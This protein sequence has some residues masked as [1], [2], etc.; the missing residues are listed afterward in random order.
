MTANVEGSSRARRAT[1]AVLVLGYLAF[2][3]LGPLAPWQPRAFWTVVLPLLVLA[4]VLGGFHRWRSVCPLAFFGELGRKLNRGVQRKV[5]ERLERFYLVVPFCFL[6]V[7]LLLRLVATNGD[8]RWLSA[9]LVGLAAAAFATN[10]RFTGK[11]W[12]NFFCP[13][14]VVERIYTDPSSPSRSGNSQCARCTA[15]KRSCP[16]IDQENSYWRELRDGGRRLATF[17]FPG[18]VLAFYGYFWLR[19]GDWEAYFDGRWTRHAADVALAFGPGFFFAPEVPA[20]VAAA[21]TLMGLSAASYALWSGVEAALTGVVRDEERRRHLVLSLAAFT[22]FSLFYF[23]AGAPTLRKIPGG[24]H[25][26]AFATPIVATVVLARRWRRSRES[27]VREKAAAKLLR[28]WPLP[29]PPPADP[30]EAYALFK[31][32]EQARERVL[33][34]YTQTMREILAEGIVRE[35]EL[36]L[37]EELRKQFGITPREHEGVVSR[38]AEEE[39]E[40]LAG[41][42]SSVENRV[43]LE[44]YQAALTEALLRSAPEREIDELRRAFG[45]TPAAHAALRE[46]MRGGAGP[47]VAR[48]RRHHAEVVAL[49]SDRAAIEATPASEG[50]D[51]VAYLLRKSE[52]STLGR[53]FDVLETV[54]DAERIAPLRA[55]LVGADRDARRRALAQLAEACPGAEALVAELEPLIVERAAAAADER[56]PIGSTLERLTAAGDPYL[57]DGAAWLAATLASARPS[58]ARYAERSAVEKMQF[59]RQ[60]PIFAELEPEDLDDLSALVREES[61]APTGTLCE[62]GVPDAGDLFVLLEGSAAV[63]V[64]WRTDDPAS[65]REVAELGANEVVGELSLLDG[66]P[67]SATVR[68]KGGPLRLL[69]IPGPAF[70][71]RLLHRERVGQSLLLT[72]THRLRRLSGRI[73]AAE[74]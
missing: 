7:M 39:R 22:A 12:C 69:R 10:W 41:G 21:M 20:L 66:S 14:G 19:A 56:E 61:V 32:T 49:R 47:L 64:R 2:V 52:E 43:Q 58:A 18:L 8:G 57:R 68:P 53:L 44:G 55:T 11:S 13:V 6:L 72:L 25:T 42:A 27:Y 54:G 71:A 35:G 36:R 29:G 17:A 46:R 63:T 62:Q 67:R 74:Q 28:N 40:L 38:L 5:P 26:F 33:A 24:T 59:L 51:F 3:V 48:A 73:A 23:F 31:A 60:V 16:D 50:R 70:R 65:E 45:V 37:F 1:R 34:G 15:C 30:T 4:I 9:L